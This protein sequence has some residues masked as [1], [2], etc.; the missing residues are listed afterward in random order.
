ML[1]GM[2]EMLWLCT[3]DVLS[4]AVQQCRAS[5][6]LLSIVEMIIAVSTRQAV[7]TDPHIHQSSC[8]AWQSV[9]ARL[10]MSNTPQE[11]CQTALNDVQVLDDGA[12]EPVCGPWSLLLVPAR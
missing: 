4:A 10:Y 9:E 3:S 11:R 1:P 5:D 2:C 7:C 12:Y 8:V 6:S